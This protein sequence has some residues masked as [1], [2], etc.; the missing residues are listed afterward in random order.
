MTPKKKKYFFGFLKLLLHFT[1]LGRKPDPLTPRFK[2][3]I[4]IG[5]NARFHHFHVFSLQSRP[6]PL[7]FFSGSTQACRWYSRS[8]THTSSR[9]L[10]DFN[11]VFLFP[12][13][14]AFVLCFSLTDFQ[15]FSLIALIGFTG[16]MNANC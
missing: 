11:P 16:K 9:I 12:F 8:Q 5:K 10:K 1:K 6:L 7:I 13:E 14:F 4:E 2:K 15:I 3:M